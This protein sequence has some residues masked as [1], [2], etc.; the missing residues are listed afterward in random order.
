MSDASA[1]KA[2]DEFDAVRLIVEILSGLK[3]DEQVRAIR[4]AQEK[5]NMVSSIPAVAA[6]S[7]AGH[8][9][10]AVGQGGDIRS[11]IE[12]KSPGS[13][14][15]FATAVAY[16]HAFVAPNRIPEINAT[17]L[18]EA[19]RLANRSRL[20][21]PLNTMHNASKQGYLDKGSGKGSFRVNTVGENLVAMS[22]PPSGAAKVAKKAKPR[23]AK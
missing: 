22:L 18:Q 15:Q 19:T 6:T 11:F 8:A 20:T 21:N 23:K 1:K 9:P 3:P 12:Q 4:W 2:T 13:D 5:L 10:P 14:V 16:Y 17:I 7:A